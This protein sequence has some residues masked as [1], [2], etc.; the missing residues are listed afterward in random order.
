MPAHPRRFTFHQIA[1]IQ[2]RHSN[3]VTTGF[4]ARQYGVSLSVIESVVRGDY[5]NKVIIGA[6]HGRN[7]EPVESFRCPGCGGRVYGIRCRLCEVRECQTS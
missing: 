5:E 6:I 3:G 2:R 1:T 7:T 4:M